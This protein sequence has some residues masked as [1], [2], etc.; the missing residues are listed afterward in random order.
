MSANAGSIQKF[1]SGAMVVEFLNLSEEA[2]DALSARM[3]LVAIESSALRHILPFPQNLELSEEIAQ[4][5]RKGGAI[6]S[7]IFIESGKIR[8]ETNAAHLA[9]FLGAS[10]I[11]SAS[12]RDVPWLL[13][14]QG[15]AATTVSATMLCAKLAGIRVMVTGGIGGIHYG[16]EASLDISADLFE[17][18]RSPV[19][20]VCSGAKPILDI[21]KT[22][23]FLETHGVPVIGFGTEY[24]P[25]YYS[26][27]T[28]LRAQSHSDSAE[29]I[30]SFL[31]YS[32]IVIGSTG[33][34]IAVPPPKDYQ[35]PSYTLDAAVSS[36]LT[37]ARSLDLTG[38]SVTPFVMGNLNDTVG[39]AAQR[40]GQALL[41]RNA[42][43][44]AEIA[45]AY[46]V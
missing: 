9:A 16:S 5:V 39:K 11:L 30:A 36:A 3:P 29:E 23:E 37:Q 15:T 31:R 18:S 22:L 13:A 43:V 1:E 4:T 28:G 27:S 40:L 33:C 14:T 17:L 10:D 35:I 46:N 21:P 2:S 25:N 19:A 26:E 7:F 44:A 34:V 24:F 38:K 8:F 42:Q 41:K 45:V 12:T 20:V 32:D 6:P